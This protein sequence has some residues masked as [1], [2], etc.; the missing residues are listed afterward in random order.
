MSYE[1]I[2]KVA[3][4]C[5]IVGAGLLVIM[6]VINFAQFNFTSIDFVLTIYYILFGAIIVFCELGINF[7]LKNFY[8]MNFFLGRAIFCTFVACITFQT[9]YW[10]KILI[11]VFFIVAAVCFVFLGFCYSA[12]EATIEEKNPP[13]QQ[14][15]E[16]QPAGQP[17]TNLPA[18]A[19]AAQNLPAGQV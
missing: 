7:V 12:E 16:M 8:F 11:S 9:D 17:A 4:I 2:K 3:A 15:V 10:L 14:A 13:R 5:H 1:A 19:P 6:S 18:A